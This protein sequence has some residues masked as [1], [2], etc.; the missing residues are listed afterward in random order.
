MAQ[1]AF[2]VAQTPSA[3][4]RSS[5]TT[6]CRRLSPCRAPLGRVLLGGGAGREVSVGVTSEAVRDHIPATSPT[7]YL[8][9]ARGCSL[10][11]ALESQDFGRG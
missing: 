7:F 10:T 1:S 5:V 8:S 6:Y 4:E 3:Q 2:P 11:G 9:S